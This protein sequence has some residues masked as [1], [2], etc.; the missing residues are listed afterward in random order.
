MSSIKR[1]VEQASFH[2]VNEQIELNCLCDSCA[3]A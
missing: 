3:A 2:L 1:Q